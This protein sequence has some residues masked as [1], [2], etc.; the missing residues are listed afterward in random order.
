LFVLLTGFSVFAEEEEYPP[1]YKVA[2]V[3]GSMSEVA[4]SVRVALE[5]NDF[6][7][8][9]EYQPG[10][11]DSLMVLCYTRKDFAG[12]SLKFEDRGALAGVM[13]VGLKN[14]DGNIDVS[15]IN[16][17]Y[18]FYAY[19]Y[20]GID[21]YIGQLEAMAKDVKAALS[22]IGNDFEPF[23]G[24]EEREDLEDYRYKIMMP[25]FTDPVELTEYNSFEE[26]LSVIRKNLDAGIGN[27]VKVYEVVYPDQKIALFGIGLLDP[28]DGEA[29]F[30][31][32]IGEDHVAA[33]PYEIIL[34]DK[35]VTMLPGR[36]RIALHWPELGM[37]TF[38]KIMSTPGNIEDFM[39]EI[40]EIEEN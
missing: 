29:D 10:N 5:S 15:M 39:L 36:Y 27:T 28:E 20:E 34:Q 37:G 26:G 30:L 17:M 22:A 24:F 40:T 25:Y 3:K 23:G 12:I 33:M 9:G 4:A 21:P 18:I 6:E 19:F 16:P 13:K 31:P 32:T 38:M 2:T 8:I 35:E 14:N 11:N 1:Y 7:V